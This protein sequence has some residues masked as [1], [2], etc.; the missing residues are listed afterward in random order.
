MAIQ[1]AYFNE[2]SEKGISEDADANLDKLLPELTRYCNYVRDYVA[3]H[4]GKVPPREDEE[5]P[6]EVGFDQKML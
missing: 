5:E 1:A 2:Q 6:D 4:M 3:N